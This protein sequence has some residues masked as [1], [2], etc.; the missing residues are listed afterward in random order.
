MEKLEGGDVTSYSLNKQPDC[1]LPDW[2]RHILINDN[3]FPFK[4]E[5]IRKLLG[6]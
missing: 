1:K 2:A 3:Y 4:S 5:K 6:K